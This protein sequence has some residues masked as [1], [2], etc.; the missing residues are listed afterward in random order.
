[1]EKCVIAD[2]FV[3]GNVYKTV[4]RPGLEAQNKVL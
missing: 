3:K 4:E 1:M 2:E